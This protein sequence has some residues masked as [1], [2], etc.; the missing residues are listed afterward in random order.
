MMIPIQGS[1]VPLY[2]LLNALHLRNT[3]LGY[4][5][6]MINVGLSTSIFLLKTFFDKMPRSLKMPRALTAVLN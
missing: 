2:V 5:L 4:I 1:F 3:R 6:A